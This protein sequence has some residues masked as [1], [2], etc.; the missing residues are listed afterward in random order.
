MHEASAANHSTDFDEEMR[1]FAHLLL[2][3]PARE[4]MTS[5]WPLLEGMLPHI[6]RSKYRNIGWDSVEKYLS[7][8][9]ER[10]PVRAIQFYRLMHDQ[11]A[12][13]RRYYPDEAR[14]ILETATAC[15]S[16]RQEALSLIDLIFRWGNP[17]FLDILKRYTG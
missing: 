1:W 7:V 10:D 3:V 17:Q 13:P 16:S 5:L 14:K 4:T 15:N 2:V 11:L 12:K 9:V 6:T 8:E